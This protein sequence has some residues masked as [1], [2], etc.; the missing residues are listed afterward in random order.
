[1]PQYFIFRPI[2]VWDL[3]LYISV[4]GSLKM[5]FNEEGKQ[6]CYSARSTPDMK[7]AGTKSFNQKVF[8]I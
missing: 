6:L 7:Y 3:E 8:Y 5:K 4:H 1:M 2:A